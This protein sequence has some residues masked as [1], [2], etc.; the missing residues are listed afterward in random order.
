MENAIQDVPGADVLF[1]WF[2]YWPDF[3]DAEVLEI[4][5]NR[6]GSSRVRIHTFEMS[7]QV[8]ND[9][10]YVCAKHVVVSFVLQGLKTIELQGFNHQNVVSEVVLT[11]TEDGLQ[12]CLEPCY[13]AAGS[14][15][16]ER[17]SIEIEPGV[18]LDSQYRKNGA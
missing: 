11:R 13:G 15:T 2:G 14:L 16:A 3:H 5:L 10:C 4:D 18:P 1:Q 12:L 9:G 6:S 7:D 17:I 8:G